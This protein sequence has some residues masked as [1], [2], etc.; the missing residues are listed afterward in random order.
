MTGERLLQSLCLIVLVTLTWNLP[1]LAEFQCA[2]NEGHAA[3]PATDAFFVSEKKAWSRITSSRYTEGKDRDCLDVS[4]P[5]YEGFP[6]RRCRYENADAGAGVFGSLVAEVV[7]LN[8]SSTQLSIWSINACRSNGAAESSMGKCLSSLRK[9]VVHSNGAQFPVVGSVVE[10]YCNSSV[11]YGACDELPKGDKWRRPRHTWFRD[12]VSVDY[13]D[14][15]NIKWDDTNYAKS[16][17]DAV[18]DVKAS[19][20]NLQSTF[21]K[22]RIAAV[23]R[24]QWINWRKHIGK[25]EMPDGAGGTVV[26]SGWR[27][28]SAAVHKA[29]CNGTS[30]ELFDALVFANP[31][32]TKP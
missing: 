22:A 31:K 20:V 6:T 9:H 8:P 4:V 2:P 26:G 1:V 29:A 17:F 19:D 13:K 27:V 28:V 11:R 30:N 16:T 32:W 23:D 3:L 21:R 12:G 24:E 18:L 25:P 7:I 15:Q 5:G 10:S 14:A